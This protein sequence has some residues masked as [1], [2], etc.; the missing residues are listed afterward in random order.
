MWLVGTWWAACAGTHTVPPQSDA[1]LQGKQAAC[2][3]GSQHSGASCS[4]LNTLGARDAQ[5]HAHAAC[6]RTPAQSTRTGHRC[7][8]QDAHRRSACTDASLLGGPATTVCLAGQRLWH[9]LSAHPKTLCLQRCRAVSHPLLGGEST[10]LSTHTPDACLANEATPGT[11]G[12]RLIVE[13]W[14]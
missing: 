9:P 11:L 5:Q 2:S 12:C 1:E 10:Q 4:T 8:G 13:C 14:C 6:R 3:Q 7:T